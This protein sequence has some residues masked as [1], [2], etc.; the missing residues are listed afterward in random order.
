M[1]ATQDLADYIT[2]VSQYGSALDEII[3]FDCEGYVLA[4]T[5]FTGCFG[6]YFDENDM[7]ELC[8]GAFILGRSMAQLCL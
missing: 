1:S 4:K 3:L 8:H 6:G 2:Q 5:T 7:L